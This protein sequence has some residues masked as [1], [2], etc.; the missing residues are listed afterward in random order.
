MLPNESYLQSPTWEYPNQSEPRKLTVDTS[1][2]PV[3]SNYAEPS[4]AGP[5]ITTFQQSAMT[6]DA[7]LSAPPVDMHFDYYNNYYQ[8]QQGYPMESPQLMHSS[9]PVHSLHSPQLPTSPMISPQLPMEYRSPQIP[10]PAQKKMSKQQHMQKVLEKINF[11][12][13]TVSE[14]KDI[15]RACGLSATGKKQVLVERVKIQRRKVLGFD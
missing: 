11:E 12:D 2:M 15:L 3:Y 8:H 4:S 13:I 5:Y 9:P 14:L 10:I 6:Y 7:P 1:F